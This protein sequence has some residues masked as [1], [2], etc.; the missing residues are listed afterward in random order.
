VEFTCGFTVAII[1]LRSATSKTLLQFSARISDSLAFNSIQAK[2]MGKY[3][4]A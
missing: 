1:A 4:S 3:F 2:L